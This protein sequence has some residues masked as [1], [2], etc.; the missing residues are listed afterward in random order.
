MMH[1]STFQSNSC[2]LAMKRFATRATIAL[3]VFSPLQASA[4]GLIDKAKSGGLA[5]AFYNYKPN[6]FFNS[7]NELVGTDPDTLRAVLAKMS[8]K[9]ASLQDTEWGNL[10]PGLKAGRFDVV[11]AGM[12]ITPE[13]CKQVAFSEP[14]FGVTNAVA[15]PKGNPNG[16]EKIE[17]VAAKKLTVAVIAGSAHVGFAKLA[18]I[19]DDKILQI[20]DTASAI[21][22]VRASRAQAYFVDAAGI[23]ALISTLP[24]KDF[25]MTKAFSQISGQ[26]VMPHGA[27]AFRKEDADFVIEFNKVLAERVKSPEHLA[28]LKS[29]GMTSEDLPRFSAAK[30]CAGEP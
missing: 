24:E 11:A 16:I 25:E 29:Y 9:I 1:H 15:Y 2:L 7:A 22:A 6:S 26:T 5:V 18:G 8:I 20:P 27:I 10:I 17:D 12:Y 23:Q 28:M 3:L 14:I 30:L 4:A 21:A 19:T 13:R